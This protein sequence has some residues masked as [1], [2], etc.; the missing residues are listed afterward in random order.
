[1]RRCTDC[2]RYSRGKP[3]SCPVCGRTYDVRLCQRGH[4]SPRHAQ[5][6]RVCGTWRLSQP[7]RPGGWLDTIAVWTLWA[8][9][10]SAVGIATFTLTVGLFVLLDWARIG[11]RFVS[12]IIMIGIVYRTSLLLPGPFVKV[13][14]PHEDQPRPDRPFDAAG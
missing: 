1:M 12:L 7:A 14:P 13:T 11:W 3:V 6:C 10:G 2:F 9:I 4:V 5:T 8:L